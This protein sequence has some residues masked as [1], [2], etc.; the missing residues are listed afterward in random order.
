MHKQIDQLK[1]GE[2]AVIEG[3]QKNTGTYLQKLL[4]MGL[5]KGTKIKLLKI[6]PLGDPVEIEVRGFNLSLRK[7][8]AQLLQLKEVSND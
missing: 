7:N 1:I 5:T 8:E 4:T 3:Y 6:A 2:E